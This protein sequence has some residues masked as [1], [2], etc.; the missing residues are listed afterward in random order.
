MMMGQTINT[1]QPLNGLANQLQ[2]GDVQALADNINR[3]FQGVAA[4]LNPLD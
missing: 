2:D 4:D 3:F 1:S